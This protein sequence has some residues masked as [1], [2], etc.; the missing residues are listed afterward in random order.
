MRSI[1][2]GAPL[3]SRVP[4]TARRG[5]ARPHRH[6]E[7]DRAVN[8]PQIDGRSRV[9][10]QRRLNAGSSRESDLDRLPVGPE[11][12]AGSPGAQQR[13]RERVVPLRLGQLEQA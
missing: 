8:R 9:R 13:E 6:L 2:G 4:V 11:R 7:A 5:H 1:A 12:P 3:P 10:Q